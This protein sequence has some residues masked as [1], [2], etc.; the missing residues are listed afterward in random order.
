[1][2]IDTKVYFPARF[3]PASSAAN[4]ARSLWH[5]ADLTLKIAVYLVYCLNDYLRQR[6]RHVIHIPVTIE[7]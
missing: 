1:M 4:V 3:D 2:T 5:A 6:S 7:R